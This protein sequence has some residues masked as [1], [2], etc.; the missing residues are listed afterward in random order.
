[1]RNPS[2]DEIYFDSNG[3]LTERRRFGGQEVIVHYDDIPPTD[4]TTVD[5]IP[6]TTALRTVIDIAPDLDR[7][8]LRRVVQDCLDRQLFSVEEARARVVE[9]DMVGRPGALLLRSLLA[10]PG[11]RGTARE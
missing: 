6:C 1:M 9:P 4:I 2:D 3:S 11:H 7:A 10:A 8:Q 5:G